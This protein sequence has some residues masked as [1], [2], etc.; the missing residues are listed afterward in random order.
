VA[1]L[2]LLHGLIADRLG[3]DDEPG[4]VLIGI[5]PDRGPWAPRAGLRAGVARAAR[6]R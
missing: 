1:G 3:E 5:E 4:S 6:T 2:S